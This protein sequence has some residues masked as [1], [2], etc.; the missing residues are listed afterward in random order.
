MRVRWRTQILPNALTY[1]VLI[2]M[3]LFCI[4]PIVWLLLTSVKLEAD[5]VTSTMQYIPRHV[6]FGNYVTIWTQSG[7]PGL[8]GNSTLTT[9]YT[10]AIC[11]LAGLPAAY[12]LGRVEFRG[13][14]ALT[15]SYLI[16]R[17]FP[18]VM[19]II[20]IFII[21]RWLHLLDTRIGLALAYTSFLLPM[22][23]W[24]MIGFFRSAPRE[25]EDAARIDGCTRMGA[26]LRVIMPIVKNGIAAAAIFVA[27]SAWN[28][29]IFA[30]MLTT[31]EGSRTWPVG[32]QLM[33][34]EFQL[35]WGPL[36]AG[37]ILSIL[38]VL[39]LFSIAQRTMVRGIA[40]GAVKG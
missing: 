20:P 5:I 10:V 21:M 31:S 37:G 28:E 9:T 17:M 40:S 19:M 16:M 2:S 26:M 29:F 15:L 11:L 6:T 22:F 30:L 7:F 12:S 34:G 1:G 13:R 8:I 35:P 27:I 3:T 4:G 33:V 14:R 24:M 32:L 25:L 36:S 38:P 39:V 23:I 18:A